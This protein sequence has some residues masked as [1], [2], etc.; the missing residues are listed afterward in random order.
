LLVVLFSCEAEHA[1][2]ITQLD[3]LRWHVKPFADRDESGNAAVI[4]FVVVGTSWKEEFAV[5]LLGILL[6]PLLKDAVGL[7]A[8]LSFD[9]MGDF[10]AVD[11]GNKAIRV[12]GLE[13]VYG[14]VLM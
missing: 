1:P 11:R 4:G 3:E 2:I 6:E 8:L 10:A 13:A 5:D 7:V 14:L 12:T 9:R